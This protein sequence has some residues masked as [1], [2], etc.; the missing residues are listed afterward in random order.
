MKAAVLGGSFNPVHKGH[1]LLAEETLK[2]GFERVIFVPAAMAPHKTRLKG[3]SDIDRLEMLAL[4]LDDIPGAVLWDGEIRRGGI[5]YTIDT[6]R[7]LKKT[8]WVEGK[9]GLIIG[10]DLVADFSSWREIECLLKEVLVI[11]ARRNDGPEI[12]F[13]FPCLRLENPVWP[14]SSSEVRQRI[15]SG[16]IPENLLP[17]A[18]AEYIRRGKLYGYPK[19]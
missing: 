13:N 12:S 7:E 17:P 11:V 3:A 16:Q 4:A 15:G 18:V 6:I 1:I 14:F 19:T 2:R 9:A 8:R 5:S 10:D